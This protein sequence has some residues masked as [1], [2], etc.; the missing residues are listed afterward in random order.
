MEHRQ[1]IEQPVEPEESAK[2][3]SIAYGGRSSPIAQFVARVL[4]LVLSTLFVGLISALVATL[5]M[6][7]AVGGLNVA[8]GMAHFVAGTTSHC[9]FDVSNHRTAVVAATAIAAQI[10]VV[11]T[12]GIVWV[13]RRYMYATTLSAIVWN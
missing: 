11:C 10:A 1:S 7:M 12:S 6:A 13:N 4:V 8:D 3:V 5:A 9:A 2:F